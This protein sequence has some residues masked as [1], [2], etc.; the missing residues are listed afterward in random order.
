M[1]GPQT[2]RQQSKRS[3]TASA[4][5]LRFLMCLT[6]NG[7][8]TLLYVVFAFGVYKLEIQHTAGPESLGPVESEKKAFAVGSAKR[9]TGARTG[10]AFSGVL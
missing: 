6:V 9:L 4:G 5:V 7:P 2:L 10:G 3:S 1:A 8:L